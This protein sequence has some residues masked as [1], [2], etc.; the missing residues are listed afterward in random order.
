MQG[1][2]SL[3]GVTLKITPSAAPV[4]KGRETSRN[5]DAYLLHLSS[6]YRD[7]PSCPSDKS[8]TR[9][10]TIRPE[11]RTQRTVR[12]PSRNACMVDS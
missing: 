8:H 6:D 12:L 10:E 5:I 7:C 4:S 9:H 11:K 1:S 2:A 3:L